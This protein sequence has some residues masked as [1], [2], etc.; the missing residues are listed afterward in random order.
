MFWWCRL[1]LK[2][3]DL[4]VGGADGLMKNVYIIMITEELRRFKVMISI[5]EHMGCRTNDLGILLNYW[6]QI[7]L[8]FT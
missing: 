6:R 8:T 1:I 2:S 4:N 7:F 3:Y 5:S